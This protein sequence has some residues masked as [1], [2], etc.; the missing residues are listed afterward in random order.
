MANPLV[1]GSINIEKDFNS[2]NV[3]PIS[4]L[5]SLFNNIPRIAWVAHAFCT[6]CFAKNSSG[7]HDVRTFGL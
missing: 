7:S 4:N 2:F 5:S 3:G 6:S 1:A